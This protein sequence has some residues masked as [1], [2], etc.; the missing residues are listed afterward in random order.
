MATRRR[1]VETLP[2]W[3]RRHENPGRSPRLRIRIPVEIE[4]GDRV[5]DGTIVDVSPTGLRIIA[6]EAVDPAET[7]RLACNG[8]CHPAEI[9]WVE[10]LEF[11]ADFNIRVKPNDA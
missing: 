2:D 5:I 7:V 9:K 8:I 11:G 3:L 10:G 4:Q 1:S 6:A